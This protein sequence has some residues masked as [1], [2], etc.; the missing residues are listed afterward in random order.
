ME[1]S[2]E[3]DQANSAGA[4][5]TGSGLQQQQQE[6]SNQTPLPNDQTREPDWWSQTHVPSHHFEEQERSGRWPAPADAMEKFRSTRS[7]F[8]SDADAADERSMS[9]RGAFGKQRA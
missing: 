6:W 7:T 2:G 5:S 3:D 9:C 4:Y 8:S 1:F